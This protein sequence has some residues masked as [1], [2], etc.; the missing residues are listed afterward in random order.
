[1]CTA[2]WLALDGP[3]SY[4]LYFNRDESRLRGRAQPPA[5]LPQTPEEIATAG[6][7][8]LAPRDTDAGG[9]WMAV[10]G[11]GI[12]I[13]VLNRYQ[14]A[15]RVPVPADRSRSRGLLV[16]DLAACTGLDQVASKLRNP[17]QEL[18]RYSAFTILAAA[19][20][21]VPAVFQ[22]T[23]R[24][25]LGPATPSWP[26]SSSGHDDAAAARERGALWREI[27]AGRGGTPDEAL[28]FHRSHRPERGALSPCMH[29]P[30]A[31]TVSLT[32]VRVEADRV[33]MQYAD[34]PPCTTPLG[35]PVWLER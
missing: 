12:T 30:V 15:E 3:S 28:A 21:E 10:N 26:V 17:H 19:P 20:N 4:A 14:D 23:G 9:T 2:T 11:S 29:R 13:C 16:R 1:M 22:W 35:E 24:A 32:V 27:S 25:L 8:I 5:I 33:G 34:G 6:P 18:D 31:S 7:P